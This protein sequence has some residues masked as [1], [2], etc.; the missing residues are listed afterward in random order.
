M[1]KVLVKDLPT[2]K[3]WQACWFLTV[4]CTYPRSAVS[5]IFLTPLGDTFASKELILPVMY[6]TSTEKKKIYPKQHVKKAGIHF[7]KWV[8]KLVSD[9]VSSPVSITSLTE[10]ECSPLLICFQRSMLAYLPSPSFRASKHWCHST[11][12]SQANLVLK[13][14][15]TFICLNALWLTKIYA[16]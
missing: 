4:T 7:I 14:R 10:Q 2:R 11:A 9:F 5:F 13:V 1:M 16:Y 8:Y 6:I 12:F 3:K 15:Y